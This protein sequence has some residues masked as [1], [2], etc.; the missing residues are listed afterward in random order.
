MR[1]LFVCL[2]NICRSPTAEAVFRA[3][4]KEKDLHDLMK[5]DS[6]GTS[7]HHEG[8]PADARS[9][10]HA[11]LRGYDLTSLSRPLRESD[12]AEFDMILVMDDNNYFDVM[13]MARDNPIYK[14]KVH[15]FTDFCTIHNVD[16]VPDP[17]HR[18]DEGFELVLDI[19][20]DASEG[21][22]CKV[23]EDQKNKK[24]L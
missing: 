8:E 12:F 19:I 2:G 4:L 17:Y 21:L 16:K 13:R 23:I 1:F 20:E 6:A 9:R 5:C 14:A 24:R 10:E 15:K 11:A 7:A 3:K 18:G 22:L